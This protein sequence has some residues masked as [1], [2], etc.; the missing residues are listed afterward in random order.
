MSQ[1]VS[2]PFT[3]DEMA[4]G[5]REWETIIS[6]MIGKAYTVTL[7]KVVSVK[8][9][10]TGPV[11]FLTA[12]DLI[13]QMDGNNQGIPNAPMHDMPYF[14]LQGGSNAVIIDPKP[15][16]IGL[17]AFCYR[18]ISETKRSKTEAPPPSLRSHDPS[19]GVY[20]GGLLNGTPQQYIHFLASGIHLQSTGVFTVDASLMQVNCG[21]KATGDI[22]DNS[23]DQA[24]S[25]SSMRAVYN[26]HTHNENDSGGPTD[27]PNQGM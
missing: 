5:A 2:R 15:G 4:G 27:P 1:S 17:A 20:F 25:M 24:Q 10:G 18:D 9:G 19:D 3:P 26:S 8:A 22:T 13:Q 14:R 16:D 6:K 23:G 7:V 12:V 11:G 21:I